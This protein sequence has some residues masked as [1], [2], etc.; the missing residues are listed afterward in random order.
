MKINCPIK[1]VNPLNSISDS[2]KV[3]YRRCIL[4]RAVMPAVLGLLTGALLEQLF[5]YSQFPV[6]FISGVVIIGALYLYVDHKL[7][8]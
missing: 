1:F 3:A 6:G 8:H 2:V 7:T 5:P 4:L